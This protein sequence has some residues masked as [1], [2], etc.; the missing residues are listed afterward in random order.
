M[1]LKIFISPLRY[2]QGP[3][4]LLQMGE[5]LRMLGIRNPLILTSPRARKAIEPTIAQGLKV[6]EITF[7]FID[8][9]GECTWKEIE[10]V[11]KAC[12]DESHDAIISCGGG[13]TLDTGRCAAARQAVNIGKSPPELI[14][15]LGAGVP[16]INVPTVAATD[17]STAAASLVRTEKGII[18][19]TLVFPANPTMV[20]VDTAVIA[21]S[22][23]RLLVA[24]MGDALATYFET[25]MSLRTSTPVVG[26]CALSTRTAQTLSRLCFDILLDYGALAKVEVE[27]GVPGPAIEA[28]VE[29]NVLLSGLGYEGGGLSAAHAVGHAFEHIRESFARHMYHGE[30]VA[31]G[32]LTQLMLEGR[33]P[34][35]LDTVFGFCKAVG[36]PMTFEELALS[37]ASDEALETVAHVASQSI[38]IRSMAGARKEPDEDG[39]YFDPAEIFIALKAVDAYGRSTPGASFSFVARQQ[40]SDGPGPRRPGGDLQRSGEVER[41]I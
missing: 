18:E 5:Q 39:R 36:L 27:A 33:N 7:A 16:C 22:P 41:D 13:K 11:R 30:L 17:A 6:S 40:Y 4:A 15:Q 19:A 28:V 26:I 20:F 8:F 34:E 14:P 35:Y 37:N 10:R 2:V 25:N 3:R 21:K 9:N 38:L 1:A 12:I 24:G 31:F 32:T 23:V 29:A